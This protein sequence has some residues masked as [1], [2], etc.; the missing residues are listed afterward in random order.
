MFQDFSFIPHTHKT[1]CILIIFTSCTFPPLYV[2]I[3]N[4]SCHPMSNTIVQKWFHLSSIFWRHLAL[5][6]LSHLILTHTSWL[7]P[8][9]GVCI[10]YWVT[11]TAITIL[12][13]INVKCCRFVGFVKDVIDFGFLRCVFY[14][15]IKE[16]EKTHFILN[17]IQNYYYF[18]F[19]FLELNN[20]NKYVCNL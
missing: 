17:F 8:R 1:L 9:R 18:Y 3:Y 11:T 2:P 14:F 10:L 20:Y 19:S 16:K 15:R 13:L 4:P 6:S 5:T 7:Q 12:M